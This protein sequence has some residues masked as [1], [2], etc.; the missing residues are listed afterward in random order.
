MCLFCGQRYL[1]LG[2]RTSCMGWESF[3]RGIAS[4]RTL[5]RW[6]RG[7]KSSNDNAHNIGQTVLRG[8][9]RAQIAIAG[10]R[11]VVSTQGRVQ[12]AVVT[13]DEIVLNRNQHDAHMERAFSGRLYVVSKAEGPMVR[14]KDPG[15]WSV[16]CIHFTDGDT[17]SWGLEG[18]KALW[19]SWKN[20]GGVK[21]I[22]ERRYLVFEAEGFHGDV[23]ESTTRK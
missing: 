23:V 21:A 14:W 6:M 10:S 22:R 8:P 19:N 16:A 3:N 12:N 5:E 20:L 1:V 11:Y 4:S 15:S 17:W 18:P 13:L 9:R 2:C 7:R